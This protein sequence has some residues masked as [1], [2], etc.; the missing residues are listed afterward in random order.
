MPKRFFPVHLQQLASVISA[1]RKVF[2][3]QLQSWARMEIL[4]SL[5]DISCLICSGL[6][7]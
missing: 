5:A 1:S 7:F 4:S 3:Q 6:F 2:N